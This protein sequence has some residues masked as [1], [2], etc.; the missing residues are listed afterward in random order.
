[1]NDTKM[2]AT[3]NKIA[4]TITIILGTIMTIAA[5]IGTIK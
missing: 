4:V 1:M 5:I 3:V 2:I